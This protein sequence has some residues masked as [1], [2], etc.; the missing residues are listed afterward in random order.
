MGGS[1][2]KTGGKRSYGGM[3]KNLGGHKNM[4]GGSGY[5]AGTQPEIGNVGA[6]LMGAPFTPS[7]PMQPAGEPYGNGNEYHV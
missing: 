7:E 2:R 4:R 5:G 6:K 3:K 1:R